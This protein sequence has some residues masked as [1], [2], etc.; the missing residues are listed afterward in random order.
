MSRENKENKTN[1][2]RIVA[3]II[4]IGLIAIFIFKNISFKTSSSETPPPAEKNIGN[5]GTKT[6]THTFQKREHTLEDP[7]GL[8]VSLDSAWQRINFSWA[9]KKFGWDYTFIRPH[10]G[11]FVEILLNGSGEPLHDTA[12]NLIDIELGNPEFVFM[13]GKGSLYF[14]RNRGPFDFY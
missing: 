3:V 1:P 11:D 2:L 13:R 10:A 9:A 8:N 5:Q 4:G 7:E 12:Q 14:K 6:A